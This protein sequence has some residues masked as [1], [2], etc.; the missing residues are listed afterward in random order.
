MK[1]NAHFF[2]TASN[3]T[4]NTNMPKVIE[5]T[6]ASYSMRCLPIKKIPTSKPVV[7]KKEINHGLNF[8]HTSE[9]STPGSLI[10]Y[11]I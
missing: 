4:F 5:K 7:I 11:H 2:S 6:I 10:N 8:N 9:T 1:L 3:I